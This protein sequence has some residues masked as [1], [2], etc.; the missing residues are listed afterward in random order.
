MGRSLPSPV[1]EGAKSAEAPVERPKVRQFDSLR[2][3]ASLLPPILF[4]AN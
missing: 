4:L 1:S 3:V 2:A